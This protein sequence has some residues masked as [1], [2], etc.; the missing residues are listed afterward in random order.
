[1]TISCKTDRESRTI[2]WTSDRT[3]RQA[4][5][6]LGEMDKEILD[7]A[8]FHGL[9]ARGT[10]AGAMAMDHWDGKNKPKRYA[11]DDEKMQRIEK[12]VNHLN[13]ARGWESWN[14]KPST[15]PLAGKSKEDL[16]KLIREAQAKIA[17]L[18]I[19][20]DR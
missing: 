20:L 12:V 18:G 5:M 3:A 19:E 15:D 2:T 8:S 10:D 6:R 14:L 7:R 16:E 17:S 1:M 4:V 13:S 11:T 9:S